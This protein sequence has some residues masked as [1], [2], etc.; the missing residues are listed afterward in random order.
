[1]S[2]ASSANDTSSSSSAVS[3]EASA[4]SELR[5]QA[6]RLWLALEGRPAQIKLKQGLNVTAVFKA[7]DGPQE[8]FA[9]TDLAAP[10]S[11]L[12]QAV[13]RAADVRIMQFN[14]FKDLP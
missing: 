11:T 2:A 7:C 13:L 10:T 14:D 1:M 5:Q 8:H 3:D 4:A 9:V 12:P 6:L